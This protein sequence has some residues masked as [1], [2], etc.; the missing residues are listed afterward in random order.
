LLFSKND[1]VSVP[2]GIAHFDK[3]APFPP[4]KY[5]ERGYNVQHWSSFNKGGHFAAMEQPEKLAADIRLFATKIP[6]TVFI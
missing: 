3:E 5:I 6:G 2:T 4:K 1:F